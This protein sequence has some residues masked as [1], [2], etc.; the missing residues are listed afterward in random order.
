MINIALVN[1]VRKNIV[2]LYMIYILIKIVDLILLQIND[3]LI[4]FYTYEYDYNKQLNNFTS[5]QYSD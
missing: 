5:L 3:Q 2:L 1:K 4:N